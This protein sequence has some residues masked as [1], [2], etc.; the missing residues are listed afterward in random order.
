MFFNLFNS[1]FAR[2]VWN[3]EFSCHKPSYFLVTHVIWVILL[4]LE[5]TE[6]NME[7]QQRLNEKSL[8]CFH[9]TVINLLITSVSS[10]LK[11]PISTNLY[12]TYLYFLARASLSAFRSANTLFKVPSIWDRPWVN[13][14]VHY[15]D[16]IRMMMVMVSRK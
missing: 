6:A 11:N 15:F 4:L 1:F 13:T 16:A 14:S 7:L 9:S 12:F 3:P 5:V 2:I 8:F 10:T